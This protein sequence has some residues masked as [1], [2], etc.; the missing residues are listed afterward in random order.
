[1]GLRHSERQ[2][3]AL[4]LFACGPPGSPKGSMSK[5]NHWVGAPVWA[6]S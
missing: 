4:P 6:P 2:G 3:G 5:K 1:M